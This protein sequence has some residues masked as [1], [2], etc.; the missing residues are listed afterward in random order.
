MIRFHFKPQTG[1]GKF[2]ILARK[3]RVFNGLV[4]RLFLKEWLIYWR[5]PHGP[6]RPLMFLSFSHDVCMYGY[7]SRAYASC[8][9]NIKPYWTIWT[10]WTKGVVKPF[11]INFTGEIYAY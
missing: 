10:I 3:A 8:E 5:G 11:L 9:N 4:H 7:C 2:E 6:I 1:M